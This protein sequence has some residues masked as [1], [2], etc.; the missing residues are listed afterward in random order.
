MKQFFLT[1]PIGRFALYFR[2]KIILFRAVILNPSI[3]GTLSNDI[4]A[5]T[6]VGALSKPNSTFIDVG[7]HIGSVMTD[8]VAHSPSTQII[9]IEAIPDKARALRRFFPHAE[10][11]ACAVGE[12]TGEVSFFINTKE[13]G[14]S[15]LSRTN[16]AR[17]AGDLIEIQVPMARLDDLVSSNDVDIIKIDVEGAELG[18]IRGA[19]SI[20][21]RCRPIIMFESGP[22]SNDG[23]G[24]NKESIFLFFESIGYLLLVPNRLGHNDPGLTLAGFLESHYYPRRCTNYFAVPTERFVEIRDRARTVLNI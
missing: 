14:Y 5:S 8:V 16:G 6:L 13:S 4:L 12:K 19:E 17:G 18:V 23:L 9:A 20:I 1:L 24:Y 11:H 7:A 10:I 2:D 15:G 22:Q 21:E 3:L